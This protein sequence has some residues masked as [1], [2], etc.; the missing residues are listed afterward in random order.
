MVFGWLSD[1]RTGEE[2]DAADTI[3]LLC[4]EMRWGFWMRNERENREEYS[5]NQISIFS[6]QPQLK[7]LFIK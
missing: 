1:G 2:A 4:F 7:V 6:N 3:S 5:F